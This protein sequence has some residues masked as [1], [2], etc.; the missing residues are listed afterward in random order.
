MNILD[1]ENLKSTDTE[2]CPASIGLLD[3]MKFIL[4]ILRKN[5]QFEGSKIDEIE[6]IMNK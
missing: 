3:Q 4:E 1:H 6:K 5:G 2:T